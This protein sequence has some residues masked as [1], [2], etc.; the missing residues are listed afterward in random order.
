MLKIRKRQ[1]RM[2]D[3]LALEAFED[4]MFR[5]LRTN[6]ARETEDKTDAGLRELIRHGIERAES[7]EVVTVT[8]VQR[9]LECMIVLSPDF[10]ES[11][12]TSW[13]GETLR[14]TDL[15]GTAKMDLIEENLNL[16]AME[17]L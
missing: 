2:F 1:L 10:D 12:K 3:E 4:E 15:G 17:I 7:Y 8:D 9:Y 11:G 14:R 5:H 6:F 13:A 16:K